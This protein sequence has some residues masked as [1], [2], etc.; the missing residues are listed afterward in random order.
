MRQRMRDRRTRGKKHEART[1][2]GG[3]FHGPCVVAATSTIREEN[4][5]LIVVKIKPP[6]LMFSTKKNFLHVLIVTNLSLSKYDPQ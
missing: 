6:F 3:D 4:K 1:E 2:K 5:G